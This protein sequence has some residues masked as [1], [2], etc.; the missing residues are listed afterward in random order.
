MTDIPEIDIRNELLPRHISVIEALHGLSKQVSIEKWVLVGGLMV[1]VLGRE[2]NGWSPRAEVTKDAD[3]LVDIVANSAV[4]ETVTHALLGQGFDLASDIGS[5]IQDWGRCTFVFGRAQI[6]VLCPD[7]ADTNALDTKD[8]LRS[9]AIPGGRRALQTARHVEIYFSD[10]SP[11]VRFRV[12]SLAGAIVAKG[13]AATDKRTALSS[14]HIQDLA[15]LLTLSARPLNLLDE[16]TDDDLKM[17]EQLDS[18]VHDNRDAAWEYLD[19][20][21]RDLAQAT[22]NLLVR[23]R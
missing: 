11:N 15:F 5:S 3:V 2:H 1:L 13:A 21:Q 16:L 12:P 10:N 19:S 14:R 8:G 7:D 17:L 18:R 6:D 23:K 22:Y 4:L 20:N 9:L